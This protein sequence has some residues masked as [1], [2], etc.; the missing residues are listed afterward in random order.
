VPIIATVLGIV[1]VIGG[2]I[3]CIIGAVACII[4]A[5][6]IGVVADIV[7]PMVVCAVIVQA[8]IVHCPVILGRTPVLHARLAHLGAE[9]L[10][11]EIAHA[12]AEVTHAAEMTAAE[13]TTEV[14]ASKSAAARIRVACQTEN[15]E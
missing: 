15:A 2:A 9:R 1:V 11:T 5:V 13:A 14:P 6:V 8:A 7:G 12:P 3:A 10:R 4:G